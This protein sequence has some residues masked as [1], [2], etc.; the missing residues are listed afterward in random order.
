MSEK[1]GVSVRYSAHRFILTD[2]EQIEAAL[3]KMQESGR[4]PIAR[5][6]DTWI[7]EEVVGAKIPRDARGSLENNAPLFTVFV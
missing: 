5:K 1:R 7:L 6:R 2:E 3:L 4:F